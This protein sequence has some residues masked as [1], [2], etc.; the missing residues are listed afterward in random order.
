[1]SINMTKSSIEE[2]TVYQYI[3]LPVSGDYTVT[4]HDIINGTIISNPSVV[5]P[6]V[7]EYILLVLSPNQTSAFTSKW[8]SDY[9][10]LFHGLLL[11]VT[12]NNEIFS[13]SSDIS[14]TIGIIASMEP[15]NRISDSKLTYC[16]DYIY[17]IPIVLVPRN[18]YMISGV[19]MVLIL[20]F[21][22]ILLFICLIVQ[23]RNNQSLTQNQGMYMNYYN[24][25]ILFLIERTIIQYQQANN[26][27]Y[28]WVISWD[29]LLI[30]HNNS[31]EEL[32]Q[33]TTTTDNVSTVVC[34][35]Y[36]ISHE[37]VCT[38]NTYTT[39]W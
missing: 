12:S 27:K 37:E 31:Y 14:N 11:G 21:I 10:M 33:L 32:S 8:Y 18:L 7:L 39:H 1:M 19:G 35:P 5:Y 36:H 28:A 22:L 20:I 15:T 9:C 16:L 29:I 26:N 34:D 3:T 30:T 2:S 13:L 4:A 23:K 38:F 17:D 25:L 24:Y 6:Q